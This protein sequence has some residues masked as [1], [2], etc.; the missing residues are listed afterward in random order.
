MKKKIAILL[1]LSILI[2]TFTPGI[3]AYAF[4]NQGNESSTIQNENLNRLVIEEGIYIDGK[5][6]S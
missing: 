4:E 5:K 3:R 2:P 1:V 6:L